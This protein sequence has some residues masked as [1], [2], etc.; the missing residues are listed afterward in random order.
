MIQQRKLGCGGCI[1][2]GLGETYHGYGFQCY[3]L[4]RLT[5]ISPAHG[6]SC[7]PIK[8]PPF[9]EREGPYLTVWDE[10]MLWFV[11]FLNCGHAQRLDR[12][13][14]CKRYFCRKRNPKK[15]LA[16]KRGPHCGKCKG[17]A[18]IDRT[19][20][21]RGKRTDEMVRFAAEVWAQWKPNSRD[22]RRSKWIATKVNSRTERIAVKAGR[23]SAL[24]SHYPRITG[25][26]VTEHQTEI[27]AEVERRK[28]ATRKN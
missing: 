27:E 24:A 16:F 8:L 5:Y 17:A 26:W 10:S 12:C 21:T 18:S 20:D 11:L 6:A 28:H 9:I 23:D 4:L 3:G 2:T 13:T 1:G 25:R 14:Y 19:E 15:N 7:R 22:G